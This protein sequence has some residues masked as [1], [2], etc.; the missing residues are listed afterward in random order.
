MDGR[1]AKEG[2]KEWEEEL[3]PPNNFFTVV[4]RECD[5]DDTGLTSKLDILNIEGDWAS[6]RSSKEVEVKGDCVWL[7]LLGEGGCKV[8]LDNSLHTSERVSTNM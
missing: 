4:L 3:D 2:R 5:V 8:L 7:V 1:R 6:L